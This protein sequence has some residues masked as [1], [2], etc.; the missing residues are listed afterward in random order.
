VILLDTHVLLRYALGDRKLGKRA[1][2]SIDGALRRSELCV[3]ALS[4]W[5]IAM[6]V[7]KRRLKLSDTPTAFR[8][9][10]LRQ[11]II[12]HPLDGAIAIRSA[13][14]TGLHGDPADRMI[15]A[16]AISTGSTLVTADAQVLVVRVAG[17]RVLDATV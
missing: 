16:T 14:L 4:F 12:E 15:A 2:R 3:S 13:E 17:L 11:G 7:E 9:L 8:A 10:T 5:E 1:T 6:L